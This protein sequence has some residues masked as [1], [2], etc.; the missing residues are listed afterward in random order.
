MKSFVIF[1]FNKY[2]LNFEVGPF[3]KYLKYFWPY[4]NL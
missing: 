1:E 2:Y 4:Y 3:C